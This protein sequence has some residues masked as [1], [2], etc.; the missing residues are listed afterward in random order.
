MIEILRK[1]VNDIKKFHSAS[2]VY[3]AVSLLIATIVAVVALLTIF[4][5]WTLSVLWEWFAVS[6]FNAPSISILEAIGLTI[7]I[8]FI[9]EQ[10]ADNSKSRYPN[11]DGINTIIRFVFYNIFR[12]TI[13]LAIGLI[14]YWLILQ[15]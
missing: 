8:S 6:I 9:R 12:P 10:E 14:V 4:Q 5:G 3:I 15:Q 2:I 11:E 7:L 13:Y 1:I